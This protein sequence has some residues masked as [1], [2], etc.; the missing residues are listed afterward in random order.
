MYQTKTVGNERV[1]QI[2]NE[3]IDT[4]IQTGNIPVPFLLLQ[5]PS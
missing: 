4:I 1:R 5:G 2:L 3:Y